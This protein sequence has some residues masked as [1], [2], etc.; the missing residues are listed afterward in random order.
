MK[1]LFITEFSPDTK[2]IFTGG[3]EARTYFTVHELR[4]RH[5]VTVIS[6][7]SA[8]VSAS[9]WSIFSRL[10]FMISSIIKGLRH[11][12]ADLVEGSNVVCYLPAWIIAKIRRVPAV[13][14]VPD[15]LGREWRHFGLTGIFGRC[16]EWFSL[17]L[18]WDHIIALSHQTKDKLIALG[19]TTNHITVVYPGVNQ[20]EFSLPVPKRN[21]PTL[22]VIARLVPYKRV[23]DALNLLNQLKSRL[24]QLKLLVIGTGPQKKSLAHQAKA[25]SLT[26]QVY[27]KSRLPRR[28]LITQL[29]S[30]HLLCHFSTV[31][32]FGLVLLEAMAAGLPYV[33]YATPL[34]REITHHGK[35]GFLVPVGDLPAAAAHVKDLLSNSK[36]YRQKLAEAK[37]L[38]TDY[39]WAHSARH[40]ET[41]YFSLLR[42]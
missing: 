26:H 33:A 14:W 13:A 32:G 18:P 1:I 31:E 19:V 28:T 34:N 7:R 8:L 11:P 36:L 12:Q 10:W 35:G 20:T 42:K 29:K 21:L 22:C 23:G 39:S 4:S 41:V 24:P 3:V 38:L 5:S 17:K 15:I 25:L 16:L 9:F 27:F 37:N 6:R 2:Q 30:C 40:T